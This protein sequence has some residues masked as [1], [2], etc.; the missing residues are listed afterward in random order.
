MTD[1]FDIIHLKYNNYLI[2]CKKKLNI[3][4]VFH[5]QSGV[6]FF[7]VISKSEGGMSIHSKAIDSQI[8]LALFIKLFRPTFLV[9][10]S[11]NEI[12]PG[13]LKKR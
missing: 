11:V 10:R 6:V 1:K 9:L 4:D 3:I 13:N 8:D 5:L 7:C 2:T 12:L